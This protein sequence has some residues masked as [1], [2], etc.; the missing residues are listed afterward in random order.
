M[1]G[2]VIELRN[3]LIQA[4]GYRL[5]SVFD[6]YE[7]TS[8]TKDV[9]LCTTESGEHRILRIGEIRPQGFFFEGLEGSVLR[10]PKIFERVEGDMPYE[11]EEYIEGKFAYEEDSENEHLG[12]IADPLLEKLIRTFWE[13][14]DVG[15]R[16]PLKNISVL[17]KFEKHFEKAQSILRSPEQV[18]AIVDRHHDFW[19]RV[20]PSKWK[21]ALD[22]LI[23]TSDGKVAFIDN[24]NVGLR[25][26]GYDLGWLIWPRWIQMR[27]DL[28]A[29]ATDQLDYL[30]HFLR[31]VG[32]LKP[33][34]LVMDEDIGQAF[35]LTVL[36]RAVG[37]LFDVANDT[38]HLANWKLDKAGNEE[39]RVAHVN[40]LNDI[41][42]GALL[43]I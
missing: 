24:A 38:R 23:C 7:N 20:Y 32:R 39:R 10:I 37:A 42:D 34:N 21:F 1:P 15:Q 27:T 30:E 40:F 12:R 35:W 14:Q 19:E 22:N 43:R 11:I 28:F 17:E 9:C 18:R 13:F 6:T 25:H 29:K 4:R 8:G 36:L 31:E 16:V 26:F 33:A 2:N 3:K 41:I 5:V